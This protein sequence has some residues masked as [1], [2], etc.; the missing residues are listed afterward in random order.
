MTNNYYKVTRYTPQDGTDVKK[1]DARY[2]PFDSSNQLSEKRALHD[3]RLVS[4][5]WGVPI[6]TYAPTDRGFAVIGETLRVAHEL[7][8]A[9]DN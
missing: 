1:F 5:A 7:E 6:S 3:A 2:F 9:V 8:W 4:L